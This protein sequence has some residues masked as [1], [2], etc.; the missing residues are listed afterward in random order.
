[1]QASGCGSQS[2]GSPFNILAPWTTSPNK[3]AMA[4]K[5]NINII[6]NDFSISFAKSE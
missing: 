5:N 6:F 3:V 1:M 4:T 2:G